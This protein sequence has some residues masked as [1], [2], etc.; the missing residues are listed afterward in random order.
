M[1]ANHPHNGYGH[2]SF[3][4]LDRAHLGA[5]TPQVASHV[6]ECEMC[7][8]Y[9][10]SLS[11]SGFVPSFSGQRQARELEPRSSRWSQWLGAAALLAAAG[12]LFLFVSKGKNDQPRFAETYVGEK[13]FRSVWIYVRRGTETQLWDG[14]QPVIAGDR[15]RLKVDA[16]T[17]QRVAVYS[18]S[19]PRQPSKLF[20]SP[21]SP[22]QTMTLP[23]A[24]EVDDSPASEQLVVV[25]SDAPITP[26]WDQWR[27]G[28]VQ[29][30]VAVLPFVLPKKPAAAA[31]AGPLTP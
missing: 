25:F 26:T 27:A 17:F 8:Q 23:E 11:A 15:L 2:P 28:K 16:G 18:L 29:P 4:A 21:L 7:R 30:G 22:G 10:A 12:C 19:D 6:H 31:D 24:W 9:L 1:K 3:L 5:E 14:K 13:G 20:E